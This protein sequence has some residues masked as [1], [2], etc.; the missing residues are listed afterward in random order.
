MKSLILPA[1]GLTSA[2]LLAA[3]AT[4]G[5][6]PYPEEEALEATG[7]QEENV[8]RPGLL[9]EMFGSGGREL[10]LEQLTAALERH[11]RER[12]GEREPL[13][14]GQPSP[15]VGL[16]LDEHSD[17]RLEDSLRAMSAD[18]P[19]RLLSENATREALDAGN[20]ADPVDCAAALRIYPG[21]RMVLE[22]ST[23][24]G[25]PRLITA[26]LHDLEMEASSRERRLAVPDGADGIPEAALD[27][28]ADQLLMAASDQLRTIPWAARVFE[29]DAEG[30][31][32]NAG[33]ADGL[34]EGD[35]LVVM[36]DGRVLRN[37]MG[38]AS[39]YTFGRNV[40]TVEVSRVAG[41]HVAV[42]EPVDG[43]T[44]R[45]DDMLMLLR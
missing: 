43:Q 42:V 45:K 17:S 19:L 14:A 6:A 2:L 30:W 44:P 15:R 22:I 26:R 20:C 9:D 24:A 28:L 41:A 33:G 21:L 35:R 11:E 10:R 32:I 27:S 25:D 12:A 37:A 3:C 8:E 16:L 31:L 4:P 29:R 38:D 23:D 40:G 5:D 13:A 34:G 39:G 36:R 18:Y 7:L 1:I